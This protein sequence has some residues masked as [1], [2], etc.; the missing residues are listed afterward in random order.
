MSL[1]CY[2]F[3]LVSTLC[4]ILTTVREVSG[5]RGNSIP[6]P[7]D[8]S[9]ESNRMDGYGDDVCRNNK[10]NRG[11]NKGDDDLC[12]SWKDYNP[13]QVPEAGSICK[14]TVENQNNK[15]KFCSR[16]ICS[17]SCP[18][19][20]VCTDQTP[21]LFC[22]R[23]GRFFL[24]QSDCYSKKAK[25]VTISTCES[26]STPPPVTTPSTTTIAVT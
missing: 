26:I 8:S 16:Q 3:L 24:C 22:R 13:C 2:F 17:N 5:G 21:E 4:V 9:D 23:R 7:S 19:G 20:T 18:L 11:K 10:N 1:R 15:K 12:D 25:V 14:V 6:C